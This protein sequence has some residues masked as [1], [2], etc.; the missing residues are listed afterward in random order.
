MREKHFKRWI[1]NGIVILIILLAS[2]LPAFIF[3]PD[4]INE[5][6]WIS[7]AV[8][9]L[10]M[11]FLVSIYSYT[12]FIAEKIS[13]ETSVF[14]TGLM[15]TKNVTFARAND[16][17]GRTQDEIDIQNDKNKYQIASEMLENVTTILKID[18]LLDFNGGYVSKVIDRCKKYDIAHKQ[19]KKIIKICSKI[20]NGKINYEKIHY[21]DIMLL[22]ESNKTQLPSV[23]Y[24]PASSQTFRLIK[25]GANFL[26]WT[27]ASTIILFDQ[28][29]INTGIFVQLIYN[30]V[31]FAMSV[32]RGIKDGEYRASELREVLDARNDFFS[33]YIANEKVL[34]RKEYKRRFDVVGSP[35]FDFIKKEVY[36]NETHEKAIQSD[37][38]GY[39]DIATSNI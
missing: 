14:K 16:L 20:M 25:I 13:E 34:P 28:T 23:K 8:K 21:N 5:V 24:Q 15:Y 32:Y 35:T 3:N 37:T 18:E 4:S 10:L 11:M 39:N 12:T 27:I 6:F 17:S 9:L 2:F 31:L 29:K 22:N 38:S 7:A 30:G 33:K 36:Y 1:A 19:Q 26:F